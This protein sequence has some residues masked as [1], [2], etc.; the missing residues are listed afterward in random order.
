M[1]SSLQKS[2]KITPVVSANAAYATLEQVGGIMTLT[3]GAFDE[4]KAVKLTHVTLLDREAQKANITLF[5]FDDLPTVTSADNE[6][7]A[8]TDAELMAKCVAILPLVAADYVDAVGVAVVTKQTNLQLKSVHKDSSNKST[9]NLYVVAMNL[10]TTPTY[11]STSS[12]K[13]V[14]GLE[15]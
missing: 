11:T 1:T 8:I 14:F 5:F 2:I 10:T 13:F 9:G 7:L 4:D 6:T 3:A 15:A 12:L